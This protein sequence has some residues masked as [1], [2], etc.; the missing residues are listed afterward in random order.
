MSYEKRPGD[1]AVFKNSRKVEGD[2]KPHYEISGLG[3]DGLPIKGAL[4]LK[5]DRN[6][7]KFMAGKIEVDQ[8]LIDKNPDQ[9]RG[10]GTRSVA[11]GGGGGDYQE[12]GRGDLRSQADDPFGD[13]IPFI[14]W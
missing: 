13:S 8:Y 9:F 4:W 11:G 10:S 1:L 3:L 2:N 6:G 12:S 5:E 14:R 7:K